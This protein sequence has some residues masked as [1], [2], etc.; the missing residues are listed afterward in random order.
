MPWRPV[1]CVTTSD[2]LEAFRSAP[3]DPDMDRDSRYERMRRV[4]PRSNAAAARAAPHAARGGETPWPFG[5][6]GSEAMIA[7]ILCM[8]VAAGVVAACAGA[9]QRDRLPM[10]REGPSTERPPWLRD[11]PA[12]IERYPAPQGWGGDNLAVAQPR[13][14]AV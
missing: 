2:V 13:A 8:A 6:L 10:L 12:Q 14:A 4:L 5:M 9:P 3:H 1:S 11:L 7:R